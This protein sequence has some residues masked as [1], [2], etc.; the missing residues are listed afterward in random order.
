MYRYVHGMVDLLLTGNANSKYIVDR[1]L[2][3]L[4]LCCKSAKTS[5]MDGTLTVITSLYLA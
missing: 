4:D 5:T 2:L 3:A 1:K